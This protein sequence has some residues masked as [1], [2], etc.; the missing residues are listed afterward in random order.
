[1]RRSLE[2]RLTDSAHGGAFVI[3]LDFESSWGVRDHLRPGDPYL[4]NLEG[5]RAAISQLLTLF[6]DYKICATWGTVGLLFANGRVEA[7][8]YAPALRPR[9]T[10]PRLDPYGDPLGASE[11]DDPLHFAPSVIDAIAACPGQEIASHT[12]SHFYCLEP[13]Q[14]ALE[15]RAD[16]LS[17]QRIAGDKGYRL[18]SLILPRNQVNPGY[19][20][21]LFDA[22]FMA[23][24]GNPVAGW[25][26]ETAGT[27]VQSLRRAYRLADTYVSLSG[28]Q[29]QDWHSV[30]EESGLANVRASAFLRPFSPA[31]KALEALRLSRIRS[32][33]EQ[34][35]R[36]RR[37]FHLWWHPHNFG[38][39]RKENMAFLTRVLDAFADLREREGL[40]SLS[41]AEVAARV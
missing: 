35:A 24:R 25:H 38:I 14:G 37:I 31:R 18:R 40:E 4:R 19:A 3:S 8:R 29:L 32:A 41:M 20:K 23:Y 22:G 30:R 12:F 27:I 33:L 2:V 28:G 5:E 34:A 1:V 10:D 13:G 7:E 17:A 16:L 39:H 26:G 36:E 21:V 15:F 11:E 6:Q 9:Y